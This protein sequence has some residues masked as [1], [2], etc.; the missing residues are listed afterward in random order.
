V[1]VRQL[2]SCCIEVVSTKVFDIDVVQKFCVLDLVAAFGQNKAFQVSVNIPN[3]STVGQAE[4]TIR[5][6][7][8]ARGMFDI[9][10]DTSRFIIETFK[11]A[12]QTS[13]VIP[14]LFGRLQ[15]KRS[16]PSKVSNPKAVVKKRAIKKPALAI[17]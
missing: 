13:L 5:Q 12:K 2:P 16:L 14:F 11:G 9:S 7:V 17:K 4:S 8:A 6:V 3:S 10:T 15:F 1:L